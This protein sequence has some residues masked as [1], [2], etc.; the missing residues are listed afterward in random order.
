MENL[1][2][3]SPLVDTTDQSQIASPIENVK[4]ESEWNTRER[5]NIGHL[6]KNGM[7]DLLKL[8]EKLIRS[9]I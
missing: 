2:P 1:T 8:K 6:T 4:E 7:D 5:Y 3:N 9:G